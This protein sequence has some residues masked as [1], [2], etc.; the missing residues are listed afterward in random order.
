MPDR[1]DLESA[2]VMSFHRTLCICV[3]LVAAVPAVSRGQAKLEEQKPEKLN[4]NEMAQFKALTGL[5]DAV[6][7]GKEP[8]PA[9]VKVTVQNHF[10]RSATNIFVPY[11]L[12]IGGG[13]FTSFPV[14]LYVRAIPKG[15]PAAAPVFSD[16]FFATANSFVSTGQDTVQLTRAMELP[17]G[18]IDV[19]FALSEA[20]PR[21]NKTPAKR[22]VHTQTISV[23]DLSSELT[24]SSIILAKSLEDAPQQ[25]TPRQQME[26]P[27]TL[28]GQRIT[29]TFTPAFSKAS[30]LLFVFLVYNVGATAE[31]KPDV[32]VGYTV[33]RGNEDKPFAKM[34]NTSFNAS[35]LPAE[36]SLTAGHQV[37]VA[38]GVPLASFAP[39]E[40]RLGMTITDKTKNQTINRTVPFTVNP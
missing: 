11:V 31:G 17:P 26:Q 38:Q 20:P 37:M 6:A 22:V 28:G 15:N 19:T 5:V 8:A 14:A 12:E 1:R 32:E 27:F 18:D 16:I 33:S 13:K 35:T 29:P 10:I 25:L 24:T 3:A 30:E 2:T 23:P 7:A 21:N 36:F 9:D 40:Y 4:R 39:G 34:P